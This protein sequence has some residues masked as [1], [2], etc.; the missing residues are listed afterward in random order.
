VKTIASK[1][2]TST[3]QNIIAT[4]KE[5]QETQEKENCL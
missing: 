3:K 2:L 1:F 4:K 5:N